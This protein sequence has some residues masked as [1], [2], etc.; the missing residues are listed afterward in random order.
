MFQQHNTGIFYPKES[1]GFFQYHF[2]QFKQFRVQ[3]ASHYLS[4]DSFI[5]TPHDLKIACFQIP[6]P[7]NT[8]IERDIDSVYDHVDHIIVVGSELHPPTVDFVRRFDKSK[9]T[10][11]LCGYLDQPLIHSQCHLF[12]DWFITSTYFYKH[13]RPQTLLELAPHEVKPYAFDALLGRKKRHRDI[14]WNYINQHL[15]KQ[16]LTTYMNSYDTNFVD[17]DSQQ[18]IWK[19][20]D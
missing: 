15:G 20:L 9:I 5:S 11:F 6:Y 1:S 3:D 14:A 12:L 18:W 17:N 4:L 8:G 13:I 16:G 19:V 10:Y 7:Y 2:S